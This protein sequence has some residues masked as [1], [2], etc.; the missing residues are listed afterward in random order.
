MQILDELKQQLFQVS[1][2]PLRLAANQQQRQKN[3]ELPDGTKLVIGNEVTQYPETFFKQSEHSEGFSGLPAM[4]SEAIGRT[5][6]EI[7]RDLL[8]STIMAG[9]NCAVKGTEERLLKSLP[10]VAPQNAKVKVIRSADVKTTPWVGG[11]ILSSLGSFQ[12]MWMSR[13]EY[14]EHGSIMIERKCP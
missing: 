1:E 14:Q 9:G 6:I 11:S 4:V 10:E 7:R 5:D 2:E 3:F 12:Q 8:I 13:Q